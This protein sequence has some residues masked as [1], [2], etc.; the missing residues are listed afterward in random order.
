MGG[1]RRFFIVFI[2]AV[3]VFSLTTSTSAQDV[4]SE[5]IGDPGKW[6]SGAFL[7]YYHSAKNPE[8]LFGNPLSVEF[9]DPISQQQVQYFEKAR[10]DLIETSEGPRVSSAPLGELLYR[11]T[12]FKETGIGNDPSVCHRFKNGKESCYG[13]WQFYQAQDGAEFLGQPLSN[14]VINQ[15]G[16]LVQYFEEGLLVWHPEKKSGE[17]VT[18]ADLGSQ[19]FKKFVDNP[20][21]TRTDPQTLPLDF[22][23]IPQVHVTVSSA[24]VSANSSQIVYVAVLDQYQQPIPGAMVGVKVKLPDTSETLY[25]LPETNQAGI[26]TLNLTIGDLNPREIIEIEAQVTIAGEITRGNAWFRIWW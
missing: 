20:A 3:L 15:E 12:D 13:F 24:V 26:S 8:I 11:E 1:S 7:T 19:Y 4:E 5:F 21:Y 2:L 25:R 17:R 18:V 10:F 14:T 23:R 9:T 16:F 22:E 6:V